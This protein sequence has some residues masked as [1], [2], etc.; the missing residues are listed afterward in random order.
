MLWNGDWNTAESGAGGGRAACRIGAL[1]IRVWM[2]VL[3]AAG[4]TGC[5][6]DTRLAGREV[7]HVTVRTVTDGN[8]VLDRSASPKQVAYALLRAIRDD[9]RA[10]SAPARQ[11]ALR[12]QLDLCAPD[13]IF[14]KYQQVHQR[15]RPQYKADRDETVYAVVDSW[16]PTYAYY[17]D[18]FDVEWSQAEQAMVVQDRPKLADDAAAVEKYVLVEM[19]DPSG[20][21]NA[22]AVAMLTLVKE[23]G[24]WRVLNV[25][26]VPGRRHLATRT[27]PPTSAPAA[28][29]AGR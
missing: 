16:A 20:D 4:A 7:P 1:G 15:T 2:V 23:G 12:R 5:R 25:G 18:S 13:A 21:A 22:A 10:T 27:P 26:F 11:E 17:V 9:V 6:Q 8:V 19:A 14:G 24:Y 29:T 28:E 3:V